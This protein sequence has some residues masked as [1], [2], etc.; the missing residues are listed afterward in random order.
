VANTAHA[1]ADPSV[2]RRAQ[3][4]APGP[5]RFSTGVG[6]TAFVV[7]ITAHPP[8]T[9]RIDGIRV[10]YDQGIRHG[11]QDIWLYMAFRAKDS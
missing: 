6:G 3:P 1:S 7:A 4:F 10:S 5:H 2:L 9:V 8:G 11:R